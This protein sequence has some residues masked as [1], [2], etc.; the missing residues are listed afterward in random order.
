MTLRNQVTQFNLTN[1]DSE[2]LGVYLGNGGTTLGFFAWIQFDAAVTA[3]IQIFLGPTVDTLTHIPDLDMD[4][5]DAG[6]HT[7]DIGTRAKYMKLKIVSGPAFDA[8]V[9]I[10]RS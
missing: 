1:A 5:V 7:F 4:V 8:D 2:T 6:P 3:T 10:S 9:V